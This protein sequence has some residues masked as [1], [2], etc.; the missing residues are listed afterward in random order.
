[1]FTTFDLLLLGL[2]LFFALPAELF[3]DTLLFSR[4]SFLLLAPLL[5]LCSCLLCCNF[6]GEL[7]LLCLFLF[8]LCSQGRQFVG[9]SIVG[10]RCRWLS[11]ACSDELAC[12]LEAGR[13][14]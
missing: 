12:V 8:K 14:D 2:L 4:L 13:G 11:R 9:C 3:L 6:L 7:R 1:M 10:F 5:F